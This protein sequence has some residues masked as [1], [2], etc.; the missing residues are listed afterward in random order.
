MA[1]ADP[2]AEFEVQRDPLAAYSVQD[3][4]VLFEPAIDAPHGLLNA[5]ISGW[6]SSTTGLAISGVAATAQ[7]KSL[8]T[9]LPSQELPQDS[10]TAERFVASAT[11]LVGDLPL[12]IFG[13]IGGGAAGTAVAPGAGTLAG[14]ATGGFALPTATRKYLMEM[15]KRDGVRSMEDLV[16]VS[17][18]FAHGAAEGGTI[19]LG[20]GVG[21]ATGAVLTRGLAATSA[22]RLA[23]IP[24]GELIGMTT[25]AAALEGRVPTLQEFTDNALL[26]AAGRAVPVVSRKLMDLYAKAGVEPAEAALVAKRDKLFQEQLLNPTRE[27]VPDRYAAIAEKVNTDAAVPDPMP[28]DARRAAVDVLQ[29][30]FGP[31]GNRPDG[32]TFPT[33]INYSFTNSPV[34]VQAAMSKLS[35]AYEAQIQAKRGG[36]KTWEQARGEATATLADILGVRESTIRAATPTTG[37]PA[38][39]E[40]HLR[41]AAQMA[42]GAAAE[43]VR[44][45]RAVAEAGASATPAQVADALA[46][47]HRASLIHSDFLGLRADVARAQNSLKDVQRSTMDPVA[48]TALMER[49][50]GIA[51]V[52][53]L[54]RLM[55]D[56]NSPAQALKL[57]NAVTNPSRMQQSITMWKA[58]GLL[59]GPTT[60]LANLMGNTVPQV[61]QFPERAVMAAVGKLKDSAGKAIKG[62]QYV[63][64][65]RASIH[66]VAALATGMHLGALDGLS[67]AAQALRS[68]AFGLAAR[69]AIKEGLSRNTPEYSARVKQLAAD[70]GLLQT[71]LAEQ[72]QKYERSP[73]VDVSGWKGLPFRFLSSPDLL[74]RTMAERSEAYALATRE[75]VAEGFH[76]GTREFR[77]TVAHKV[78]NLSPE[79]MKVL[80]AAG[81]YAVFTNQLS[82]RMRHLQLLV[83][84]SPME[85]ILPFIKTPINLLKWSANFIP[86]TPVLMKQAQADLAAGGVRADR[87]IARQIIGTA[88]MTTV[89]E[90]VAA[91]I[92]T[93]SGLA[94]P[95]AKGA[96]K[97]AGWQPYSIKIGDTYYSYQRLQPLAMI[98][99]TAADAAELYR[100]SDKPDANVV[101]ALAGAIGNSLVS[102]TYLQ[103]LSGAISAITDPARHGARWVDQYAAS[104]VPALVGQT[105][106]AIDPLSREVNSIF[107]AIQARIPVWREELLPVRNPLTGKPTE[108]ERAFPLAP[109]K[110]SQA[111][112]DP[113][114][115]EAA[116]LGIQISAAPKKIHMGTGTGKI[117]DVK[118]AD[119]VRNAYTQAQGETFH[120]L[121]SDMVVDPSWGQLPD[122]MKF[123]IFSK[124]MAV[125]RSQAA[126][127]VLPPEAREA[128]LQRISQDLEFALQPPR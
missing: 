126:L 69:A 61:M 31:I 79:T 36:V 75:A 117:G 128:E 78:N 111:A 85:F 110:V 108:P 120:G 105:A 12:G 56:V 119:E 42:E 28:R 123:R 86:G 66:E 127:K 92:I 63:A 94:D 81:D 23:A 89:V 64:R 82:P 114:L 45:G 7:G 51:D 112:T 29:D 35:T 59:S 38:K 100:A 72:G 122:L 15:Y 47:V 14:A 97:A 68:D 4:N 99:S 49:H 11:S 20:A 96:K 76:P 62:E 55:E 52:A 19:G 54:M 24:A 91:G 124:V 8:R 84:G 10:T 2:L 74:F 6:Q 87:V 18:E 71:A 21:G 25:T 107:E 95:D 67:I 1:A 27:T 22:T 16:A 106:A 43:M 103:G 48:F 118:L 93:G 104:L 57:A 37:A 13:A 32:K 109:I 46:A 33:H 53:G 121:M 39:I 98:L 77:E 102:Q 90:G 58:W 125:S 50:G 101:G 41:A 9:A 116:R 70:P 88:V 44:K 115:T 65:E 3:R 60:F 26:I 40:A 80:E 5:L 17:K 34:E 30:P 113:V 73:G 83:Q